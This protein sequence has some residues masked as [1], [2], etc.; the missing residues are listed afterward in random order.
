MT[1]QAAPSPLP[2]WK[3]LYDQAES[4]WTKP[5]Q[6]LLATETVVGWMGLTRESVLTQQQAS[7]EML[8]KH[9]EALRLPSK[10]D[11][12][13][14]ASQVVQLENKVEGLEEHLEAI[15]AKLDRVLSQLAAIAPDTSDNEGGKRRQKA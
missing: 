6:E 4:F 10:S 3:N 15:S 13:R 14:L 9:W 5:L 7:R 1:T 12:A 2:T 8:E 11:H